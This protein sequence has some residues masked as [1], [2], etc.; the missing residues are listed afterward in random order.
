MIS[1]SVTARR[2]PLM[3]IPALIWSNRIAP[4]SESDRMSV[5]VAVFGLRLRRY[6][7]DGCLST[8][9]ESLLDRVAR[10]R[11]HHGIT[12]AV[13]MH[14]VVAEGLLHRVAL[15][16]ERL[17]VVNVDQALFTREAPEPLVHLD[18]MLRRLEHRRA[19]GE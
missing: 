8:R 15:I 16:G 9:S 11:L 17:V 6:I 5:L 4:L 12:V 2:P 7:L 14:A 13:G 10:Q 18:N 3:T 19:P 1:A